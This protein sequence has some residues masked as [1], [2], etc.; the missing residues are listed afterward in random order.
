MRS[1]LTWSKVPFKSHFRDVIADTFEIYLR[2]V[3]EVEQRVFSALGWTGP[4]WRVKNACRACCYKVSSFASNVSLPKLC[5]LTL[6][7]ASGRADLE[8]QSAHC[9]GRQLQSQATETVRGPY[10]R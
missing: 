10:S 7:L 4:G 1:A 6:T 9:D 8:V 5:L 3:R 2:I